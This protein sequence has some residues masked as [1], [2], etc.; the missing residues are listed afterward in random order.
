[1]KIKSQEIKQLNI[2]SIFTEIDHSLISSE[3]LRE[4]FNLTEEEKKKSPFFEIPGIKSLIL[5][6]EKQK[7]VI[8]ESNKLRINDKS[9]KLP[10]HSDLVNDFYKVIN[11]NLVDRAKLIA[12]GFNY[13]ILITTEEEIDYRIFIGKKIL[14]I[15]DNNPLLDGGV[16]MRYLKDNKRLDL[17]FIPIVGQN[18][19]FIIHLNVHYEKGEIK[20][21]NLLQ[22]QFNEGYSEVQR[23]I[24]QLTE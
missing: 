23:I 8:F 11:A 22:V 16:R 6:P 7:E 1:M 4:I 2:T 20:D 21:F 3:K 15:L 9:G 18:K 24:N 10:Q 13:D 19:Q 5:P 12:Y 14:S 17:Q